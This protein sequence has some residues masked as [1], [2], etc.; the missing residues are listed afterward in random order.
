M[1]SDSSH[2]HHETPPSGWTLSSFFNEFWPLVLFV[3]FF[4][5]TMA[6]PLIFHPDLLLYAFI[7][8]LAFIL[9]LVVMFAL[10]RLLWLYLL[11]CSMV[12]LILHKG[13]WGVDMWITIFFMGVVLFVSM[14][15]FKDMKRRG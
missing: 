13:A 10:P 11:I 5:M 4:I 9:G 6:I 8:P 12:Y 14:T 3:G 15:L 7:I 1:T 2:E